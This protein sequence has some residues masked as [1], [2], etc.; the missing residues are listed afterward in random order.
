MDCVL[1]VPV[2]I[3]GASTGYCLLGAYI[4]SCYREL[5]YCT[6]VSHLPFSFITYTSVSTF[7]LPNMLSTLFCTDVLTW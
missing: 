4:Y 1:F 7:S 6:L 5:R 2:G 3:M